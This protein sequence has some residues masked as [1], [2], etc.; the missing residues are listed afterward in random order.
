MRLHKIIFPGGHND[1]IMHI[2]VVVIKS[3]T[4]HLRV[5]D[6]RARSVGDC[7]RDDGSTIWRPFGSNKLSGFFLKN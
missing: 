3:R 6:E 7:H 1:I 4:Q 5:I 2:G